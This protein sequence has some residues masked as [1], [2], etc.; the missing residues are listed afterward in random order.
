MDCV[1]AAFSKWQK[2]RCLL[3]LCLRVCGKKMTVI[4][5]TLRNRDR[6]DGIK[7]DSQDL[8]LQAIL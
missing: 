8:T 3:A 1:E 2:Q 7:C 6:R 4:G 5:G